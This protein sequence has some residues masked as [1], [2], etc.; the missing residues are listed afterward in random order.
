MSTLEK[1]YKT[2][3]ERN[4]VNYFGFISMIILFGSIWGG[5]AAM[6]I[7]KYDAGPVQLA[8]NIGVTMA[9]N[10]VVLGQAPFKWVMNIFILSVVVNAVLIAINVI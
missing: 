6:Y 10:V 3:I 8:L 1:K 4:Q 2:F 9:S 5:I 7:D